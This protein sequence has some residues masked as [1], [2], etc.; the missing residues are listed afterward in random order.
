MR[1]KNTDMSFSVVSEIQRDASQINDLTDILDDKKQNHDKINEEHKME[2]ISFEDQE[3]LSPQKVS[4]MNTYKQLSAAKKPKSSLKSFTPVSN[5]RSQYK[6]RLFNLNEI[7][8][9]RQQL[10]KEGQMMMKVNE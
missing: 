7:A 6:G 5:N 8:A 10:K 9:D 2:D 4:Q 3:S 1:L